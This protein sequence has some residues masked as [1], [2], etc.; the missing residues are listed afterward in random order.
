MRKSILLLL[1]ILMGFQTYANNGNSATQ[2]PENDPITEKMNKTIHLLEGKE[3]PNS[4]SAEQ[5]KKLEKARKKYQ[6]MKQKVAKKGGDIGGLLTTIGLILII[7]GL[8][9]IILG[10]LGIGSGL[11]IS[12]GGALVLGLI[13]YLVGKYAF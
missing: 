7:V 5:Q 1:C 10:V 8:V 3:T 11:S 12:G 2:T 9:V 13:L 4:L 6:K